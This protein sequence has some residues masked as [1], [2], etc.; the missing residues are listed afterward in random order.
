MAKKEKKGTKGKKGKG[1]GKKAS[2]VQ[3]VPECFGAMYEEDAE[4][5]R[6]D[7]GDCVKADECEIECNGE[8]ASEKK[9]KKDPSKKTSKKTSKKKKPEYDYEELEGMSLKKLKKVADKVEV[10]YESDDDKEDILEA[11]CEELDLEAPEEEEEEKPK[12][13]AKKKSKKKVV[14][15]EE[16]DDDD[17]DDEGDD[18]D[19]DDEEE[20][21]PKKKAK[22]KKAVKE[23]PSK[24]ELRAELAE[25]LPYSKKKLE[26]D[27]K[28]REIIMIAGILEIKKIFSLGKTENIIEAILE[29]QPG[30]GS[31]KKKKKK[32]KKK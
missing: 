15:E 24:E 12:K 26:G 27:F 16:D 19:D 9:E 3:A 18:D 10:E 5:C 4:E 8:A 20:E 21:K 25:G 32:S 23:G 11:V 13:K 1:K 29:A 7:S 2:D 6:S 17:D 30:G 31:K 28:R 14:E 22:K